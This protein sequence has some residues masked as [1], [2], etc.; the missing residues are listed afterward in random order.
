MKLT[1]EQST[2][3]INDKTH[4][5]V[6]LNRF[7]IRTISVID[8]DELTIKSYEIDP[9]LI[10]RVHSPGNPNYWY[11]ILILI[12]VVVIVDLKKD[13]PANPRNIK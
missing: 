10:A 1:S 6:F 11:I 2:Y 7:M 4:Q 3:H 8:I 5:I 9:E 13:G 12:V